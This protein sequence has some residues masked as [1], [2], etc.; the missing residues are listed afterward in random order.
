MS[1]SKTPSINGS[2]GGRGPGG[3]FVKGNAGGPGNPH[4]RKVQ[5]LRSALLRGVTATDVRA[6]VK[7]LIELAKAGDVAAAREVL[8]RLFGPAV[9]IDLEARIA[10]LENLLGAQSDEHTVSRDET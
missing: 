5:Q 2:N 8:A 1:E 4:V 6:V 3:R 9:G 10:K 7:K